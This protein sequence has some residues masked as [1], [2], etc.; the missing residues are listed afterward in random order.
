MSRTS[1][2]IVFIL[3]GLMG[4]SRLA[5][6]A[7]K[8][9]ATFYSLNSTEAVIQEYE[10]PDR[11]SWQKPGKVIDQLMIK[12]GSVIADIG[13]GSGYFSVLLAKQTGNHGTVYAVDNDSEMIAYLEER[14]KKE[15]HGNIKPILA[16]GDN[17]RLPRAGV[18]LIFVCNTYMFIE[19]RES[20]LTRLK[21]YLKDSG[22]LAIIS[23]NKTETPEGPPVHT[24]VSREKTIQEAQKSGFILEAE[25]FFL[26]YQ[27]FLL[28]VKR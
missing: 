17:S 5:D 21:D 7:P 26:P 20:F 4:S 16:K 28:F 18:D 25:Y 24:R 15:G 19:N 8:E 12:P 9:G 10:N 6:A 27:H 22:R 3:L 13:S 1:R 11:A 14:V 23:Y 2:Y